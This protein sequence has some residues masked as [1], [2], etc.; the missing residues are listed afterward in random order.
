MK[1]KLYLNW[2]SGKDCTLSL[3]HLKKSEEYKVDLLLTSISKDLER[4]S[5]HGLHKSLL[6]AQA[7]AIDLP[8]ELLEIPE[9]PT[10]NT[11]N[12][13]M[14][15]KVDSLIARGYQHTA[16]GDIFLEDLRQYREE[17][18]E[19]VGIKAHFP[20]WKKDTKELMSQF[21]D[22]GFKAVVVCA[23][24]KWFD[25]TAI[26]LTID[27]EWLNQLPDEVDPCGENGEFHTF[28]YDGPLFKVEV[29]FKQGTPILKSYPDPIDNN[30]TI[31]FWFADLKAVDG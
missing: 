13:V 2:S 18:L 29:Q 30:K 26:G 15:K 1:K 7:K 25:K 9:S 5:M 22:L 23:N 6:A 31:D 8:L 28:C 16:F 3:Y 14:Q 21:L 11:Y 24:A 10:M 17:Q 20:L 19:K 12:E 27:H 4:V